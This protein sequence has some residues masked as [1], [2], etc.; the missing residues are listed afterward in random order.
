MDARE[1]ERAKRRAYYAKRKA[2]GL[3]ADCGAP[4]EDEKSRCR[5][6][7]EKYKLRNREYMRRKKL[8]KH[9]NN[10]G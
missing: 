4:T 10:G 6:C 2:A 3:C 7:L 1:L 5:K 9:S 8:E